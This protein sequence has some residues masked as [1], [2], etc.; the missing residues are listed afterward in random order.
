MASSP[1]DDEYVL[2]L[3]QQADILE[4][5]LAGDPADSEK[6]AVLGD[7]YYE[8]AMYCWG[9]G[10]QEKEAYAAKSKNLLLQAGEEVFPEPAANLKIALL[11]A[12]I[13]NDEILAEEYFQNTLKLQE[14]YPEAHFYYGVYLSSQEKVEK[15]LKH[16]EKVLQLEEE[17]S[18]L[19]AEAL[20]FLLHYNVAHTSR[21]KQ[22]NYP[23]ED[24]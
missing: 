7:I 16:W 5:A 10:L 19:A 12:F 6:K 1:G 14:D 13:L 4:E 24:S 18:P 2:S 17:D 3:K 11:A 20:R 9:R 15:A 23:A 8:L 21:G 22:E